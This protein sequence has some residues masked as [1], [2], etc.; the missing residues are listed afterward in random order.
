MRFERDIN[1]SVFLR[2]KK[3]L[4]SPKSLRKKV[5]NLVSSKDLQMDLI[6]KGNEI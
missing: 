1:F 3:F 2:S 6:L 5:F 4:G